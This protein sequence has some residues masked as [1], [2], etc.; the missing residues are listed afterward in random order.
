[1]KIRSKLSHIGV[2]AI[3]AAPAGLVAAKPSGSAEVNSVGGGAD[4]AAIHDEKAADMG[5]V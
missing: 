4:V 5:T 1:M 3:T 2:V